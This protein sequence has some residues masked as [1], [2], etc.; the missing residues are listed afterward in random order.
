MGKSSNDK[1]KAKRTDDDEHEIH[2]EKRNHWVIDACVAH[3]S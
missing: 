1:R 3:D 2:S